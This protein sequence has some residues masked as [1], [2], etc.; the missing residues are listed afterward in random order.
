MKIYLTT[1]LHRLA[2]LSL[3]LA[4]TAELPAQQAATWRS[5]LYPVDWT[6][7]FRSGDKFLHDFSYA[8]Y[9][10]GEEPLPESFGNLVVDVTQYNAA[11]NTGADDVT[12]KLQAA[13]DYVGQQGGGTVFLP[14]GTY[15][16]KPPA[17]SGCALAIR[18][19]RVI[20]KGAG[21]DRTFI[22]CFAENMRSSQVILVGK[23]INWNAPEDGKTYYLT[24]DVADAP[25]TTLRLNETAGLQ[26]GDWV[27]VRSNR[28]QAWIEE[29]RMTG[30]WAP[31]NDMGV[32]FY[33]RIIA[34]NS[35]EQ[36][37]TI[38]I[39][40][41]YAV[42]VRDN[43]R[44][45]RVSPQ[46]HNVGLQDF[47]IGNKQHPAKD[48]WG[49]E[50][51]NRQ[52]TGAYNVHAAFLIKFTCCVHSWA[53][54]IASWQAGNAD[55]IHMSSNG[56]D[57]DRCRNLTIDRCDF[58]YPQ[59]RGG[60]G[61][62]YALNHCS[63]ECLVTNCTAAGVRHGFAFK[64][65]YANG[66][67]VH[68]FSS[69]NPV[70][71]SDFHMYLSM[72]NLID[73]QNINGDFIE[74]VVRPYGATAGNYHG[75][76]S[77]QTVFWNTNGIAYKG[78]GFIIDSRQ[79]GYGY[80]IGTRGVAGG[81]RT[82]PVVM[83]SGYGSVDTS[84]EDHIEGLNAGGRLEPHSL[85]YDQLRRRLGRA[86]CIP[87]TANESD[88]NL[89]EN[90]LDGDLSTRWSANGD[91]QWIEFCLGDAPVIVSGVRIAFHSGDTR[92]S[93]FEIFTSI[94]GTAWEPVSPASFT[95]SGSSLSLENF[96]FAQARPATKVRIVGHGNSANQWNS[97]TEV[98]IVYDA[99]SAIEPATAG[100][101][102]KAFALYPNPLP[103]SGE[104]NIQFNDRS[105]GSRI[106]ITGIDGKNVFTGRPPSGEKRFTIHHPN[107]S[108]GI[109]TVTLDGEQEAPAELLVVQ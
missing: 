14:A 18:H 95:G 91:G 53:K 28:S 74:S 10:M 48:G 101:N 70:Y 80:I 77:S 39:P 61:N 67:V 44:L 6:P 22:R 103:P 23:S 72:S 1:T 41:R 57:I 11:D 86:V 69:V 20:L 96:P 78:N 45:Y 104:L 56:L 9:M 109:Y 47:S 36:T 84:P 43:A 33:R 88:E 46:V 71:A 83:S 37:V 65:A 79:H 99:P 87:V 98:Q 32:T 51:Y 21:V 49:E 105:A 3:A 66:N 89:P 97:Y 58:S 106:R 63:Q 5:A 94:D 76:T 16:V 2:A 60:G 90:V 42:K 13:I 59:Y 108:A 54:N 81:V 85:Y 40:T 8:G 100:G 34:V 4:L 31:N 24:H 7:A 29:H 27:I 35:A 68:A 93:F 12:A 52:G 17:G 102:G 92:Q 26:P 38:D 19:S 55:R 30:F 82:T 25:A 73:N 50:D 15:K 64:Y 62:G 107:L 75:V